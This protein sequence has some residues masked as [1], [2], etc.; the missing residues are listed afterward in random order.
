VLFPNYFE[1]C[2]TQPGTYLPIKVFRCVQL[3]NYT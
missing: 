2:L 3:P 1:N